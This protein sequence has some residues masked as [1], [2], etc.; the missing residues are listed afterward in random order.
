MHNAAELGLIIGMLVASIAAVLVAVA[1]LYYPLY[2]YCIRYTF[3]SCFVIQFAYWTKSKNL[4]ARIRCT[5]VLRN[6]GTT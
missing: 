1:I 5:A 2:K 4:N 6:V 3:A